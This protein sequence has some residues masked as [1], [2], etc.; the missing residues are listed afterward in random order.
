MAAKRWVL[1]TVG[2]AILLV[3][4]GV[5]VVGTM[6]YLAYKQTAVQTVSMESPD[7]EFA[8]ARARFEGQAPYIDF[9]D[10]DGVE[11]PVIHHDQEK[12]RTALTTVH[13]LAWGPR[14]RKLARIA[15][16][17]WL[18]R[19]TGSRG[20][21]LSGGSSWENTVRLHVTAEE[22]ERHGPGLLIDHETPHG[23][24]ILVWAE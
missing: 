22:I 12:A 7:A 2:V 24:R 3:I 21:Q 13:L 20:V 14:D 23:E 4:V 17:F 6:G 15:F 5:G 8:K 11:M 19:L 18:L 10:K 1:I 9:T 16:P